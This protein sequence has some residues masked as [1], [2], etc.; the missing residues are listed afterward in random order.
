MNPLSSFTY[1]RRHKGQAALL[2]ALI[3]L[4]IIGLY[5]MVA[6]SWA[7]FVE[8]T[9][10]NRL[11]LS[12][13]S[14]VAPPQ[15][16]P[17][18]VAQIRAN[19][20]VAQVIPIVSGF[21]ISLPDVIGGETSWFN[22]FGLAEEDMPYV[23][24]V[25]GVTLK[26]GRLPRPRAGEIALSEQVVANLGL[27]VGDVIDDDIA[28][29]L[30]SNVVDPLELVGILRGDVRLGLVSS[31]YLSSHEVYRVFPTRF[32]VVAQA[33]R[34][35]AVDAWL[36]SDIQSPQTDV[37]TFQTLTVQIAQEYRATYILVVPVIAVVATA[38]SLV[39]GAV[40]RIAIMRR[41]S[42]FGLLHALGYG[43][44]WLTRRL[45]L[46]TAA[47]AALGWALGIGLSWLALCVLELAVFAPR[48]HDL[49]V[50]TLVPPI[51][52]LLVP[53][54]VVGSTLA[55]VGSVFTRLDAVAVVEQG[56]LSAEENRQHAP[57]AAQSSL[58]PLTSTTFYSRHKRRAVSLISAMVLM[59]MAV[60]LVVF[61]FAAMSDAQMA[62]LGNLECMSVVQAGLGAS[63]DPGLIAQLR[64]HPDVERVIP[65]FQH[66]MLSVLIPPVGHATINP[67]AV[68]ADDM[69]ALVELYSLDLQEGHLPRPRSNELVIPA[70]VAHNRNLHV[71]DVIGDPDHP[72]YPGEDL[73]LPTPFVISGVFAIPE[74]ENWLAFISLE[75]IEGHEGY[76]PARDA[77]ST[78]LVVPK[79]GRKAE[80]DEWLESRLAG[81]DVSVLTHQRMA[82]AYRRGMRSQIMVVALLEGVVAVV[83]A[84][85]LAVLSHIFA[86]QRQS[87]FGILY[88][89]GYGRLQLVWRSVRETAFTTGAA[90]GLSAAL[91]LSGLL[92][93][94][95]GVFAPLGLRLNM[96]N[97]T[98]WLFTL[99]VP[100]AVVAVSGGTI[101]WMLARLDPVTVIEGRQ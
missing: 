19:P 82:D 2:L 69:A 16:D 13:F 33:G 83:A 39:V 30:Y 99:P 92:Y 34:E 71:G 93:L 87:E 14:L 32:L 21:G 4:T 3:G 98:P 76:G 96:L 70:A 75:F 53:A 20:D 38:I 68:Y 23:L 45:A 50:I 29:E 24:E 77:L 44:R 27:R 28:P 26:E 47:L 25:C 90:W 81:S 89:L 63:I 40:N 7:I 9:R 80:L 15:S 61:V 86:A 94:R 8:P 1:Y 41:L 58:K 67:Y 85:S 52:V 42:E 65:T 51:L 10:S 60:T 57:K 48:G 35:S 66:T 6:L 43:K 18:V 12:K 73:R 64:T 91:C 84:L 46:E 88:A 22:L 37:L 101:G 54:A 36:R 95:F 49:S 11:F 62:D 31:E 5:L 72:A 79:P 59:I 55:S 56:E 78:L 100:L 97:V 17:A 74:M